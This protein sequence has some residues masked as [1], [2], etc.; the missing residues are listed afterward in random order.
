MFRQLEKHH[1]PKEYRRVQKWYVIYFTK[2]RI[3]KVEI[4]IQTIFYSSEK[5]AK[6]KRKHVY[7]LS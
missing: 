4:R 5:P 2:V 6:M 7:I 1:L 3:L